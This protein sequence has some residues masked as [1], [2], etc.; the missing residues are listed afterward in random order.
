MQS[1]SFLLHRLFFLNKAVKIPWAFLIPSPTK[2]SLNLQSCN[3][4]EHQCGQGKHKV[5]IY[6][7]SDRSK[8]TWW[9]CL[10]VRVNSCEK[11]T[12]AHFLWLSVVW[13]WWRLQTVS[14]G[15][16]GSPEFFWW[17]LRHD[18]SP[19]AKYQVFFLFCIS[20]KSWKEIP[21]AQIHKSQSQRTLKVADKNAS[22]FLWLTNRNQN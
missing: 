15:W 6:E 22:S 4:T 19:C 21:L 13:G 1:H 7:V 2:H 10:A 16:A 20:P 5:A 11:Y 9:A 3:K 14:R 18:S 12:S 17:R 8:A